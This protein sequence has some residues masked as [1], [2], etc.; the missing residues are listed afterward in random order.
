M[1]EFTVF[2]VPGQ[3]TAPTL[4]G[5]FGYADFAADATYSANM[6]GDLHR[7][8]KQRSFIISNTLNEAITEVVMYL[9]DSTQDANNNAAGGMN[10]TDSGGIGSLGYGQYTSEAAGI[11]AAHFDSVMVNMTMGATAP[12]AGEVQIY[13]VEVF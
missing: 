13:V 5:T 10:Y 7:N 12:T 3:V 9:F 4:I 2:K 11:L 1:S 6:V 8:A